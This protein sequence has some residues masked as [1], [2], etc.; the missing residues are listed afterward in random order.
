MGTGTIFDTVVRFTKNK[1][2]TQ[3]Y[4]HLPNITEEFL[5]GEIPP[6]FAY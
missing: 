1:F 6:S 2:S 3:E 4:C 5:M